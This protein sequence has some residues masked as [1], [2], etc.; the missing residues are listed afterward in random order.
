MFQ[1]LTEA[2]SITL[3]VAT[4]CLIVAAAFAAGAWLF[5]GVLAPAE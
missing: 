5:R 3:L 1:L 2:Q 4:P